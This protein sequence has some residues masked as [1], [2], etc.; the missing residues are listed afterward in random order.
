MHINAT[1]KLF[2]AIRANSLLEPGAWLT[3]RYPKR[4]AFL[5]ILLVTAHSQIYAEGFDKEASIQEAKSIV[6]SLAGNLQKELQAAMKSGGPLNALEVCNIKAMPLTGRVAQDS[7]ALVSRV[8]LKNR[9][10]ANTPNDWQSDVLKDFDQRVAAGEDP[11]PMASAT[12][13]E[14]EN[15]KHQLRFM[16][17][18]P[19]GGVCLAC[20]GQQLAPELQTKLDELYPDDKATGYSAGEVRGAFVVVKDYE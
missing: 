16:K 1:F 10:P 13:T 8:S 14:L 3:M 12:V 17:A 9:N 5:T 15:G 18:I 19:T 11:Q 7:G 20:H 6:K 4:L 2:S